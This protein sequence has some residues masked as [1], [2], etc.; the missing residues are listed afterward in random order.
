MVCRVHVT[1]RLC[2]YCVGVYYHLTHLGFGLLGWN[3]IGGRIESSRI[4]S[5]G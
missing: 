1:W 2:Y 4:E 5:S 3:E